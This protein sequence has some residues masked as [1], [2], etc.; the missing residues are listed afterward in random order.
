MIRAPLLLQVYWICLDASYSVIR[1]YLKTQN[2]AT[3]ITS[4]R[5][6]RLGH[7]PEHLRF[8]TPRSNLR[9]ILF[10]HVRGK[11][12]YEFTET[13]IVPVSVVRPRKARVKNYYYACKNI[14]RHKSMK[15]G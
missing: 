12:K 10:C 15:K 3:T 6:G 1:A 11:M 5:L 8:T 4:A 7:L 14:L 13:N 2:R 9:A